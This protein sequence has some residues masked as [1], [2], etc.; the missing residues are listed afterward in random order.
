MEKKPVMCGC[1]RTEV[2]RPLSYCFY[3]YD[4][5]VEVH[6]LDDYEKH[7]YH[8]TASL[9]PLKTVVAAR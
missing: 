6:S 4:C 2:L 5:A 7:I 3:C 9:I 1:G 8:Y